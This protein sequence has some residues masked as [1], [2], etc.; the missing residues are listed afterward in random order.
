MI[1]RL[2]LVLLLLPVLAFAENFV[3]GQDY[4]VVK[5]STPV[6]NSGSPQ[7]QEFFSFGCHWCF[8]VEPILELWLDKQ[9]DKIQF[10]RVPVI[11]NK[12]WVYYAKA[13]YT[14]ALL[15]LNKKI[16]PL[17]F[18]TIQTDKQN[19]MSNQAMIDF[20]VQQGVDKATA[21][22]AFTNSTTI[23]LKINESNTLMAK[24][25]IMGVPAFIVDQ[26]YKTDLKM[27]KGP[28]RLIA[29]LDF[30]VSKS[31]GKSY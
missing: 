1:K 21:E 23:D 19:L 12:D 24:Y 27:A 16:D 15:G 17:L 11:F 9:G 4:E 26:H 3:E 28:E 18:K 30:L 13:Y 22:S 7:V 31:K 25:Q 10:S 2:L 8:Q 6:V 5:N 29:V 14:A 20:F